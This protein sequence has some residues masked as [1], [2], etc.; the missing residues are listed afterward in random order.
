MS[1]FSFSSRKKPQ[2]STESAE[3]ASSSIPQSD[4]T[5]D[6]TEE[7]STGQPPARRPLVRGRGASSQASE[8]SK[9]TATCCRILADIESYHAQITSEK[10]DVERL[11]AEAEAQKGQED[12]AVDGYDVQKAREI[13][14]ETENLI[15]ILIA[16]V[17]IQSLIISF[18]LSFSHFFLKL[19]EWC[20]K[21]NGVLSKVPVESSPKD[22]TERAAALKILDSCSIYLT[23]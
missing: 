6:V 20:N 2:A 3:G 1:A 9:H 8:L 21:L 4:E 18:F 22:E 7:V 19:K 14:A 13:L 15:P 5:K 16:K 23:D 17:R 10:G 12:P 11:Q